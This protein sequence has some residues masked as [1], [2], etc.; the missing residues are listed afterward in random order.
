MVMIGLDGGNRK[1]GLR[2]SIRS[3]GSR[4]SRGWGYRSADVGVITN[5]QRRRGLGGF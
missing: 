3:R 2:G 4:G 1:K 5:H